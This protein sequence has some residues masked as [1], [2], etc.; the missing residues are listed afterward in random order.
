MT[1]A[2]SAPRRKP[3][4]KLGTISPKRTSL[5]HSVAAVPMEM[6]MVNVSVSM[7]KLPMERAYTRNMTTAKMG[8]ARMRWVTI[9]SILSEVER[10]VRTFFTQW[11]MT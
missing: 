2:P 1:G 4:R 9:R 11:L 5:V 6:G 3:L 10:P 8:R 7:T